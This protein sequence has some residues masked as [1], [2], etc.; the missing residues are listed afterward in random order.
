LRPAFFGAGFVC[1][2][3]AWRYVLLR[4]ESDRLE[5]PSVGIDGIS[6]DVFGDFEVSRYFPG[7]QTVAGVVLK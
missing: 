4:R 6:G 5:I 2:P 1:L 3:A 7:R